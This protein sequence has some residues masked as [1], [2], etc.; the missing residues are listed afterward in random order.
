MDLVKV[1]NSVK[2]SLDGL[3]EFAEASENLKIKIHAL[4]VIKE[5]WGNMYPGT[6]FFATRETQ[7]IVSRE[8]KEAYIKLYKSTYGD[9][10]LD[11]KESKTQ[12]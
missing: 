1:R 11:Y 9:F 6:G 3:V 8:V 2:K 7:E 12:T 10:P 5:T 4:H